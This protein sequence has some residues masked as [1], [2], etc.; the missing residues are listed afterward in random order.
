[1][2]ATTVPDI[3]PKTT[4]HDNDQDINGISERVIFRN[5]RAN[6][7]GLERSSNRRCNRTEIQRR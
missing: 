5:N 2:A 6:K 3:D 7:A 4:K 1:M